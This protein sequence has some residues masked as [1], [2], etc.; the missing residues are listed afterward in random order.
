M[1]RYP[2]INEHERYLQHFNKLTK[3]R[4]LVV[5]RTGEISLPVFTWHKCG[6][7]QVLY[8]SIRESL[9]SHVFSSVGSCPFECDVVKL[10]VVLDMTNNCIGLVPDGEMFTL[11][12]RRQEYL[13]K[14]ISYVIRC[15]TVALT[16][17]R[18]EAV[19]GFSANRVWLV[20]VGKNVKRK[21]KVN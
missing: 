3:L 12:V 5:S 20:G 1:A 21:M 15:S 7:V 9:C 16:L 8:Y 18:Q 10:G 19:L 2:C 6:T 11:S 4:K 13:L 17:I 14:V